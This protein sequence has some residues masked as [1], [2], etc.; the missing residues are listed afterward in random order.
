MDVSRCLH[1]SVITETFLEFSVK[2]FKIVYFA[3]VILVP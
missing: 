1:E 3:N 2:N